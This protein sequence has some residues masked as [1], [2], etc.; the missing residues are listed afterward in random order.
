MSTIRGGDHHHYSVQRTCKSQTKLMQHNLIL[1]LQ[2]NPTPCFLS[3]YVIVYS[4]FFIPILMKAYLPFYFR[5]NISF[6]SPWVAFVPMALCKYALTFQVDTHFAGHFTQTVWV[7]RD[8][9]HPRRNT[10][11]YE[12][13]AKG[14]D[15]E[16]MC[17]RPK[18][19][20][21]HLAYVNT[22]TN[23]VPNHRLKRI[24]AELEC[25]NQSDQFW[26]ICSERHISIAGFV[27][28]LWPI[29]FSLELR[30]GRLCSQR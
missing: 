2:I 28:K 10:Y 3:A 6:I 20:H 12:W 19:I 22:S 16:C 9:A 21:L 13:Q 30:C 5:V 27:R 25:I 8:A 4:A 24:C 1:A 15:C 29:D 11:V 7:K 17:F 18:H 14:S 26:L 23:T